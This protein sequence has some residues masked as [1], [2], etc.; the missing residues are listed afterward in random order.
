MSRISDAIR[1]AVERRETALG[2]FITAGFPE[3]DATLGILHAIERGGADFIELGMPFS[4]PLAEG[5]PIQR[6]SARALGHG[7]RM[8]DTLALATAFRSESDL[9]MVLMG[10]SNPVLRFGL[11]N[12]FD[13]AHSSGVDG[14]I[15]PDVPPEEAEPFVKAAEGSGL[16]VIMLISPMTSDE[17]IR[18]I[19]RLSSGFV[20]AVSVTGLTGTSLGDADPISAYLKR[21]RGLMASNPLMVGFGIRSRADVEKFGA[22][23]DGCIVGSALINLVES[24]WDDDGTSEKERLDRVEAFVNELKYGA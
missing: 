22:S 19:D 10:Y 12:F 16:D 18:R 20:Y 21:A 13:A 14:V 3:P 5:L 2:M 7:M 9:P 17:R 24:L 15:L 11:S 6:S 23:A 1:H 8:R 4:D